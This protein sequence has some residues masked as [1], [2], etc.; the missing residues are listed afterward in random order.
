MSNENV[1]ITFLIGSLVFLNSTIALG[2][3]SNDL[4]IT[5]N[6]QVRDSYF[7]K[8]VP[9][10]KLE[11]VTLEGLEVTTLTN[12]S[13]LFK[14]KIPFSGTLANAACSIRCSAEEKLVVN[15]QVDLR[16][17][18]ELTDTFITRHYV[19]KWTGPCVDT[20]AP[21]Y[22]Q[23]DK[24][25]ACPSDT[26]RGY[27]IN[28]VPTAREI[29]SGDRGL[30]VEILSAVS[31]DEPNG[32]SKKR[33]A[34]VRHILT[35]AGLPDSVIVTE[36]IADKPFFYCR[37]CEGCLPKFLYGTGDLLSKKTIRTAQNGRELN[38]MRRMV[39]LAFVHPGTEKVDRTESPAY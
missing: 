4:Q 19:M 13:G 39:H 2:Q 25:L 8:P 17:L 30:R 6:G 14:L 36:D 34:C 31:Y 7:N 11:V 18:T 9:N 22:I 35:E 28:W 3:G 29:T 20:F 23:F 24:D 15:D 12:D 16:A 38:S 32:L 33:I 21:G 27:L 26:I 1:G 37:Y 10:A 5:L